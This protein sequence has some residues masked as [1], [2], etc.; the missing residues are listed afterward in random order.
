MLYLPSPG[1]FINP[2][3]MPVGKPE[4]VEKYSTSHFL[5]VGKPN[6]TQPLHYTDFSTLPEKKK[7]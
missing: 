7:S 1:L 2:H 3:F 5:I 6:N 4:R